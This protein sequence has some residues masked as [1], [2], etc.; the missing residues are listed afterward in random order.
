MDFNFYYS[1]LD[2]KGL[3]RIVVEWKCSTLSKPRREMKTSRQATS[4]VPLQSNGNGNSN[5]NSSI[6]HAKKIP[7]SNL[8]QQNIF[9]VNKKVLYKSFYYFCETK[10]V[11]ND[12]SSIFVWSKINTYFDVN[13]MCCCYKCLLR[14]SQQFK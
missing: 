14:N 13:E 10:L 3:E 6:V 1:P 4:R 8:L 2:R 12:F 7:L 9:S 5:N 11:S